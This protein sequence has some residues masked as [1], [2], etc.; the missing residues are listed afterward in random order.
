[1]FTSPNST[2]IQM[3]I[4]K[5][6]QMFISRGV[7]CHISNDLTVSHRAGFKARSPPE[8]AVLE[9]DNKR[10]QLSASQ[11]SSHVRAWVVMKN[12]FSVLVF[13]LRACNSS[14]SHPRPQ[15]EADT[16]P[17]P[18]IASGANV[19]SKKQRIRECVQLFRAE[20]VFRVSGSFFPFRSNS[21]GP[22]T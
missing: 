8:A 22:R 11:A 16:A 18:S 6:M 2:Q 7:R 3:F 19:K 12:D 5:E 17:A 4:S 15:R 20:T 14:E 1:M 13:G 10:S 9:F 21:G